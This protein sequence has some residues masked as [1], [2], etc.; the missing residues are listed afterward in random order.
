MTELLFPYSFRV[1]DYLLIKR[2]GCD[3][4]SEEIRFWDIFSYC[5]GDMPRYA[6]YVLLRDENGVDWGE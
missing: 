3:I 6:Y 1:R 5:R 2:G 4:I